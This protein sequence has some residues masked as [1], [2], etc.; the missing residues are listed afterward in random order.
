MAIDRDYD[1]P[2]PERDD[3]DAWPGVSVLEFGATWCGY[4][5]GAQPSI[6]MA[7]SDY[8]DVRHVKVAD[9]PGKP[10]GRSFRVK[11]WPTLIILKDGVEVGRV[12]RPEDDEQISAQLQ[13]AS[14]GA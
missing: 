13:L 8:P 6:E 4:C 9:G 12:V 10:L 2:E 14:A 11:L 3:V 7:L 5:R 1:K